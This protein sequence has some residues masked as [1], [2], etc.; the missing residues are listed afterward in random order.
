[1][2]LLPDGRPAAGAQVSV[3]GRSRSVRTD[4][5]GAFRIEPEPSYP[6]T[7]VVT[8]ARGEVY[9]PIAIERRP[10][11]AVELRL[12]PA[13][14]ESVTVVSGVAPNIDAPPAAAAIVMGQEDLDER[15]PQ[16]LTDA[17]EGVAG[18]EKT[19]ESAAAVPVLRGLAGGRTLLLVDGARVA[20]ER[21]AGSSGSFI[22]PF[23]L[24]SVE[25][26]RGPGSVAYGSDAFGG[27][28]HAIPRDPVPGDPHVR[29]SL[30]ASGGGS[31]LMAAAGETSLDALGGAALLQIHGRRGGDQ[32][33]GDGERTSN[34]SFADAGFAL[35]WVRDLERGRLRVALAA[36]RADELERP[37]ID[38]DRVRASYPEEASERLTLGYDLSPIRRLDGGRDAVAFWAARASSR[39][40]RRSRRERSSARTS[41]RGTARR[42]SAV[43]GA[44]RA[45]RFTSAR[46]S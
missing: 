29:Y 12:E 19:E 13:F 34:S 6:A 31:P 41:K 16:H 28:I 30:R 14:R 15:Q 43:T 11:A 39:T 26:S 35:R 42:G 10:G 20:T 45:A 44:P 46:S 36:D 3:I 23:S 9:P 7:L 21:R 17:L 33:D 1:M 8:G 2:V 40:A 5:A 4:A 18:L 38:S 24:A 25:V 22:D 27:V 37:A 32:R